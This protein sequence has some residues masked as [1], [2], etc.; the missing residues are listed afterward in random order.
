MCVYSLYYDELRASLAEGVMGFRSQDQE[1]V[2]EE[3]EESVRW[4]LACLLA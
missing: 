2:W 1:E 4:L 3:T